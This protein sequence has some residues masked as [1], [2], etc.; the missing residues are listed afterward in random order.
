MT[1]HAPV[2]NVELQDFC[3]YWTLL[4]PEGIIVSQKNFMPLFKEWWTYMYCFNFVGHMVCHS[5]VSCSMMTQEHFPP[6]AS[7]LVL[8]LLC[9]IL[10][11]RPFYW[12]HDLALTSTFDLV[13]LCSILTTTLSS[14]ISTIE[15]SYFTCVVFVT[16]PLH[17]YLILTLTF[18]LVQGQI[19]KT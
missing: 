13:Q 12:Y 17:W 5:L 2:T 6:I 16:S 1:S 14:Q 15:Y 8:S 4:S 7:K 3:L 11:P 18:D 9:M 10:V 19:W